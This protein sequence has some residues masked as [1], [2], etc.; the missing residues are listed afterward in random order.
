MSLNP[1]RLLALVAGSA[2]FV[3]PSPRPA[4]AADT[5]GPGDLYEDVQPAFTAAGFDQLQQVTLTPQKTLRSVNPFWTPT[6]VD[7][8]VFPSDQNVTI[9]FVY[10]S[11][12][13][14]HALGYLY[15]SDLRARGY[16]NAQG[17]LVDANGNG[18]ADLHED[19]YNLAPPSGAQARPYIGVSPRCSRTFTSGGF[20]YRQ[21]DLALN[22]T[23][24]SAFITHPD[25]TDARPG[26]T[27]SS[28]NITVDVVGSSPP[29]AAGTG[30]SDNGLFTRIPNLLEPAHASNNHMGIGHLAFLLTDDDSDTVTFQGLGTV[31]DVMDLND[32]VPDY[33][34]SAYDSHGRPRT[35]NPD[36][37]ITT[38]DRTV[39]LGVIPGG[40]EVV[41]FLISAFDS[42]HNTDNGTVYPCLRRDADLKCTLHLR[43]PLNVFFS[44]AKW[45]LDQDFMGQNPVVSRNMGC[46]YNEACTPASSRYA[47]TLAGTTQKMCG[48]L[49]DWT[50]ERLAT[51]PYGN[52]TLPMAATTVAAPGNLVMPHAVLGNVG[53]ASDRWLLA[54]EDLPGGGDRD[55]NDVVFML[56]NWAP[57][58]GRVRS[59]VL[60][61]AAPS[62]TIQ[63]VYI[64]KDDAQDP[65]CAAPVAINYSVA[66]DCR[67][68]LAGTCV[69]NPSPTWHPV[70]FDWNRD[71][72]LDV[73]S[74]RG[75]QLC[76]KADLTAGNGP[77]QA[78]INNV[79]IGYESG[80]VVP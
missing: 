46:D 20:S 59:T 31:T 40:Q 12:G 48:W 39:D 3:I 33:D 15:M 62:C 58:A 35:S 41:F 60:S 4:H 2:L 61:P 8:I 27:S 53:P 24:A 37:G 10:E 78:T 69:T 77:C 1:S 29:G 56:R 65:S 80:P 43:T 21:P 23:C 49:D 57:T 63:Q 16:V 13:A 32:G 51:L 11:A 14:S 18:V 6:S 36:P 73:S 71:A 38:Y 19:L 68:C 64:H 25:L 55:F 72:V 66:T 45:N 7:S 5:C 47:C 28:Y 22:A 34:V 30:Y 26:R 75:H 42:S 79:D 50:R 9:S 52:T 44:K 74:T 54:F 76:W 17:D 70:T 67:V